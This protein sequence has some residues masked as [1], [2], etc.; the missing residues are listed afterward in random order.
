MKTL[1]SRMNANADSNRSRSGAALVTVLGLILATGALTAMLTLSAGSHLMR[2]RATLRMEQAFY[3]AEGGAERMASYLAGGGRV[4]ATIDGAIGPGTFS[5]TIIAESSGG[6]TSGSLN[7]RININPNNSPDNI[8]FV[9]LPDGSR[10]DRN[11]LHQDRQDYEGPATLVQVRP[12]GPGSQNTFYVNGNTYPISNN[13]TYTFR[14]NEM[15]VRIYND[16]RNPQG[17]ATGQWWIQ[18]DAANG[19]ASNSD[20]GETVRSDT[21]FTIYSIGTVQGASRM[22]TI[23]GVRRVSWAKYALWY[24]SEAVQLWIVGGE[25]FKGPV[26]SNPQLRFHSHQVPERGQAH[27]YDL[28]LT[29]K[30]SI[31]RSDSSVNPIFDRGLTL[32]APPQTMISVDFSELRQSASYTLDGTTD[33]EING[34]TMYVTNPRQGWTRRSMAVPQ[35]GLIYVRTVSTGNSTTRPGDVRIVAPNGLAGRLTVVAER[36]ILIQDHV[37]YAN[38]PIQ[39]PNSTDALGLIAGRNVVVDTMA[40]NDLDVFAHIIA[41]DGGFGVKNYDDVERGMRGMLNVYGGIVNKIRNAVGTTTGSGYRKH[42]VYDP[43]F[44]KTPPPRY[45]ATPDEFQ[46]VG[47]EG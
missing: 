6:G 11:D 18:M 39:N 25:S 13:T 4:P 21:Q 2:T 26:Y 24:D 42:Y 35:D 14:S 15:Q 3:V 22:V 7:G 29:T 46:W 12:K 1:A 41:R 45:P 31:A 34:N 38:N 33:I 16:H 23:R 17:K 32:N 19:F 44:Q 47:W 36:D 5:A 30:S 8:F 28:A 27:F 43:R 40:P 9:E 20:T 37:R 10:I